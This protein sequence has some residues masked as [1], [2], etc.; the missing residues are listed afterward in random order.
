[1][2]LGGLSPGRG[3]PRL[4]VR[5]GFWRGSLVGDGSGPRVTGVRVGS[6][7]QGGAELGE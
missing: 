4:G 6:G 5:A 1:M 3:L 2:R 7:R